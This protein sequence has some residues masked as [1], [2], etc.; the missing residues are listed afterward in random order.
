MIPV[1]KL[2]LVGLLALMLSAGS[3]LA[4]DQEQITR[5]PNGSEEF[6]DALYGR[7]LGL[8]AMAIGAVTFVLTLPFSL[9]SHSSDSAAKGLVVDPTVWTFKRPLGRFISC[10]EQPDLCK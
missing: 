4:Y 9:P 5:E 3:V 8:F 7:P 1:R 6:V 2:G 10:D